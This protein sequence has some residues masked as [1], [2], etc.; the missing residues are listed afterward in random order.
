MLIHRHVFKP[1]LGVMCEFQIRL[2]V[3]HI[4]WRCF[5]TLCACFCKIDLNAS[6]HLS[7][8]H[9]EKCVLEMRQNSLFNVTIGDQKIIFHD[10]LALTLEFWSNVDA[11]FAVCV[12]SFIRKSVYICIYIYIH[13]Q[14]I[15]RSIDGGSRD[16]FPGR[17]FGNV[18]YVHV[19]QFFSHQR[20]FAS[21]ESS[22]CRPMGKTFGRTMFMR[23]AARWIIAL[24]PNGPSLSTSS[25][26]SHLVSSF[27]ALGNLLLPGRLVADVAKPRISSLEPV[28]LEGPGDTCSILFKASSESECSTVAISKLLS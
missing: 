20:G 15:K 21:T 18:N 10:R 9:V 28:K 6:S 23:S 17:G 5:E 14:N 7:R 2:Y 22:P 24:K 3:L 25:A 12:H 1:E 26:S 8:T 4:M 16:D 19:V 11:H 13:K 27:T